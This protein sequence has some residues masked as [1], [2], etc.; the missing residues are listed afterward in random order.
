MMVWIH[1]LYISLA[2]LLFY[3]VNWIGK[4]A[5]PM[6][7]GYVQISVTIQEETAPLF[8]YLFKV[9]APV[10]YIIILA[11]IFQ[12]LGADCLNERI[13]LIVVYYWAFRFLYIT[14]RGRL[15]LLNW[16]LQILY[17]ISSI[18]LA[19]WVNS[20]IDSVNSIL[21]DPKTL[22]D[23]L[24]ILVILFLYSIFN[25]IEYSRVGAE[26]RVKKYTYGKYELF[27]NRYGQI[28]DSMVKADWMKASVYAIMVYEDFNRPMHAR[29]L[30]CVLFR[31]SKCKHSYGIM[32]VMSD[33]VLSDEESIRKAIEIIKEGIKKYLEKDYFEDAESLYLKGLLRASFEF[34][35]PGDPNYSSEVDFVFDN[36]VERYFPDIPSQISLKDVRA[37]L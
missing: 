7:F 21:P 29:V 10:V 28:I 19:I 6:D 4:R 3:I 14:V 13:Y 18:L 37:E 20:I 1:L 22:L 25:R 9:L 23:E 17:W 35:N 11:V 34:Y 32:Q 8:N 33:H 36:L 2:V 26:R 27:R 15:P 16:V 12:K 5:K 30:E 24:W 31:K